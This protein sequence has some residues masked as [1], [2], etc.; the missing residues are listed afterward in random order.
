MKIKYGN[1]GLENLDSFSYIYKRDV[2]R[3]KRLYYKFINSCSVCGESF[4]MRATYPTKICSA[5]C[6][7]QSETIKKK[8]SKSMSGVKK[9]KQ[10]C[11]AISK[12]MSKGGVIKKNI[13][14]FDTYAHQIFPI[15]EV[16]NDNG[17]LLVKCSLCGEWFV[18]KRTSVE[19]RAQYIKGNI[20]RE[21]K[22]YCS[23]GCR[24]SC[25]IFNK[26][27]YPVGF[28]VRKSRN[29]IEYTSYELQIWSKEVLKR[30][31]YVCEYCG[32]QATVAHHIQPKKL[33]SFYALDPDNGIACCSICHYKF[34]HRDNCTTINIANFVC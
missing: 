21:S 25:S 15:E 20:D 18:A 10:E 28:N 33:E 12:R 22:L 13:P 27:K 14:L 6:A 5:N 24:S 9:S 2:F 17:I 32:K 31:K 30:A 26:H 4:F 1:D 11:K 19:A 34:G 29:I 23:D 7:H 16:K 8:I 3:R